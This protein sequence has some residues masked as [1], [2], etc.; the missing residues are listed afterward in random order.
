MPIAKLLFRLDVA[1]VTRTPYDRV[2]GEH[3][4]SHRVCLFLGTTSPR[5]SLRSAVIAC[6]FL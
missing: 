1:K 4:A 6:R 5:D 3:L 2:P